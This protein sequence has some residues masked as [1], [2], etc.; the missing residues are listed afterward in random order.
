[1]SFMGY[2]QRNFFQAIG[3]NSR[4][5]FTLVELLMVALIIGLLAL[6]GGYL[7]TYMVKNSVFIPNKLSMDRLVSDALDIMIEGDS[8][9]KGLRFSRTITNIQ[10]YQ[11][12]FINQDAQIVRYRLE[13][14]VDPIL[15]YRSIDGGTETMVPYYMPTIG[16]DLSVKNSKLFTY[17]DVNEVVTNNPANVRWITVSLRAQT[18]DGTFANW[19]GKSDLLSSVAVRKF[20]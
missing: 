2:N 1:M 20:Q 9:A 5:G 16:V 19:A 11:V 6:P 8:Q 18:W 7:M 15:L 4:Q 17:Y 12:T 13:I 3:R 14:S 10:D